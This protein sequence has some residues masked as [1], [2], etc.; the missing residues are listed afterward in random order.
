MILPPTSL[1]VDP[2][3]DTLLAAV[4]VQHLP[5]AV[6]RPNTSWLLDGEWRFSPDPDDQGFSEGWFFGHTYAHT[7]QWPGTVETH[8]A[9]NPPSGDVPPTSQ[10]VAWYEREFVLPEPDGSVKPTLYQLTVG[11]CGYEAR[12]WLNDQLLRTIEGEDVH[13]GEYTSFSYE[14]VPDWFR[15]VNR[16]TVRIADTLDADLPRGK[17]RSHVY[18]R[19]DIWYQTYTGATRSIWIE[20]VGATAYGR[21]WGRQRD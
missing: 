2:D 1:P 10:I 12:V 15:P 20:E 21:A 17:Q 16:L 13:Y 19:G 8:M 11:A 3:G 18:K 14:L 6:S 7:A 9:Q 4:P 5:R